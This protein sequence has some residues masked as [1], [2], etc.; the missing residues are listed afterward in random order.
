LAITNH[1]DV[2]RFAISVEKL[3]RTHPIGQ[4]IHQPED[5]DFKVGFESLKASLVSIIDS[6]YAESFCITPTKWG[7]I[8]KCAA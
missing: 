2:E 6:T 4:D 3:S 7:L 5:I 8:R 1:F